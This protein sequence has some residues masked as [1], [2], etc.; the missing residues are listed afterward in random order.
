MKNIYRRFSGI[1]SMVLSYNIYARDC[2]WIDPLIGVDPQDN[3][4]CTYYLCET[5]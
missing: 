3:K 5:R 1:K 2:R 4:R